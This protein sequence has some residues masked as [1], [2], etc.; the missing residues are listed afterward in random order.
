[1]APIS[2]QQVSPITLDLLYQI[3]DARAEFI[4]KCACA[5]LPI[6]GPIRLG[7]NLPCGILCTVL[8]CLQ[9]K[10]GPM[11]DQWCQDWWLKPAEQVNCFAE[12]YF[13]GL[14]GRGYNAEANPARF[15]DGPEREE[16]WDM[17]KSK[18]LP[19]DPV[20]APLPSPSPTLHEEFRGSSPSQCHGRRESLESIP[21]EEGALGEDC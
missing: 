20:L 8:P 11:P 21:E 3:A 19:K 12:V 9:P 15:L 4:K 2:S 13:C 6:L 1:M 18:P 16:M 14:C 5:C 7:Y 10:S 17:Q